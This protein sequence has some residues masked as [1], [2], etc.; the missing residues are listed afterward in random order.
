[1]AVLRPA[2]VDVGL[3]DDPA[4]RWRWCRRFGWGA[5]GSRP[6]G[7]APYRAELDRLEESDLDVAEK[8]AAAAAFAAELGQLDAFERFVV[9]DRIAPPP[10]EASE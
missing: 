4:Y 1:M 6:P 10:R 7:L 2:P 5:T 9:D 3:V 8:V